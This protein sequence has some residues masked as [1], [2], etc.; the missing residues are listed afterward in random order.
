MN[1]YRNIAG[2]YHRA[3]ELGL[4]D[5]EEI[6][7]WTDR[8]MEVEANPALAF[9]D[10]SCSGG[11]HVALLA[12]LQEVPGEVDEVARRR[13]VFGL[14]LAAVQRNAELAS[15]VAHA[16]YEMAL[17]KDTADADAEASMLRFH[18]ELN[19]GDGDKVRAELVEFLSQHGEAI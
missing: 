8:V 1:N 4:V 12:A 9:I 16:L 17:A 2:A 7:A 11:D 10:A 18:D 15:P 5:G 6:V 3:L 13:L 19:T 14:M